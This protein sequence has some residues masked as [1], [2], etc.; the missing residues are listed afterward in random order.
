MLDRAAQLATGNQEAAA[1][2]G[3][4]LLS[5]EILSSMEGGRH[6]AGEAPCG[7][8]K[9]L[10]YLGPA[11]LRAAKLGERTVISTESLALQAQL[12]DKDAPVVAAA[13]AEVCQTGAPSVAILK[14]WSNTVCSLAT[15]SAASDVTNLASKS[16]EELSDALAKLPSDNMTKLLTWALGQMARRPAGVKDGSAPGGTGRTAGDRAAYNDTLTD[17]D[18]S[19]ISTTPQEC[20]GVSHCPFG[21]GCLPARARDRAAAADIV[22]TNH[23]LLAIQ[24]AT[25][26][27]IVIGN[28][29]LGE[30]AHLVVDEAHGLA[31]SVR[32]QGSA[33][34]NSLRILGISKAIEH[35]IGQPNK[36]KDLYKD[37][38]ALGDALTAQLRKVLGTKDRKIT[39]VAADVDP[40]DGLGGAILSWISQARRLVPPPMGASNPKDMVIRLGLQA[41]LA[42]LSADISTS[43]AG[44]HGVARWVEE[45][46][47]ND[48]VTVVS[49]KIA[50]VDVSGL[51]RANLYGLKPPDDDD[52]EEG[53]DRPPSVCA[54][55][56]TLPTGF[57]IDLGLDCRKTQYPSPF[58]Q[59]YDASLLFVPKASASELAAHGGGKPRLDT[60]R[61]PEWAARHVCDLVGANGGAA[62]VLSATVAAGKLYAERLR[63]AHRQLDVCSQWDGLPLRLLVERW[64]DDPNSVLVGTRSLMTG[65]DA[66]GGTCSLVII[67]RCPRSAGN[68]V[69]DARVETLVERLKTD[70]WSADRMVYAADAALLLEQAAGR[71]IRSMTD[72]GVLAVLDP[73]L[74][75]TGDFNY[76]EPTRKLYLGALGQFHHRTSSVDTVMAALAGHRAA[77]AA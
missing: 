41:R 32:N 64:R 49:L 56:A 72:S 22:I 37:A 75:K 60:S 77:R 39:R 62:L 19:L 1:R 20:P 16:P 46:G 36:T 59:A 24:A 45:E 31:T 74:L 15:V 67:D 5:H 44:E 73:R 53:D 71:L 65:V 63:A 26:A 29:K 57:V 9:G 61:H 12:H 40:L 68:P 2:P 8:G 43:S 52:D 69:D 28:Q 51:L 50:P 18:W 30:F 3:Q 25:S 42:S 4:R 34:I 35:S 33:R 10:S 23:V 55:S 17:A 76:P 58:A 13:V 27:P 47:F 70:R 48:E 38:V 14:G 54:V 66:P 21:A 7:V 6:L 11:M